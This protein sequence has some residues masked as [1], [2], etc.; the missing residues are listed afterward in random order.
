ME[1]LR[2]TM[3][4]HFSDISPYYKHIRTTDSQPIEFLSKRIKGLSAI[5]AADIGCGDGRYDL[6]LFEHLKNL[7]LICVDTN[8]SM[9]KH[10]SDYLKG[11]G[12]YDFVAVEANAN[13]LPFE[14]DQ[15]DCVFIFNA[16]HYFDL[17]SFLEKMAVVTKLGG[18]FS[19]YTR[20]Q[21]QNAESIWGKYFPLFLEKE[22]RLYELD[23][24]HKAVLLTGFFTIESIKDF[25]FHRKATLSQLVDRV[26][27]KFY[28]TFSLYEIHELN[29]A[30]K[31]FKKN[32][33]QN[34]DDPEC[35]EWVDENV[36]IL[37]RLKQKASALN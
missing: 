4:N 20:L 34:F 18:F 17:V 2:E 28:S 27:K 25:Q 15:L 37:L 22:K 16:I 35:I 32:I 8:R 23:D 9:L 7:H 29:N 33:I 30:L 5:T 26:R 12:I 36:L 14:A 10:A 11:N 31:Q 24:I 19:I 6:L 3:H 13:D 1:I 21:S